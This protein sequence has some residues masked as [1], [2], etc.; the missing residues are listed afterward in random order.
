MTCSESRTKEFI[1]FSEEND[2]VTYNQTK[3]F[4]FDPTISGEGLS[5]DDVICTINIPLV[6][7]KPFIF[8]PL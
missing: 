1:E 2:E 6:V 7:R 4:F 8:H 5:E 3:L